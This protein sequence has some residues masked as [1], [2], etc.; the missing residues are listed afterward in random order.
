MKAS[1]PSMV[2][3][4]ERHQRS[5]R[6][7]GTPTR[8]RPGAPTPAG[9][10]ARVIAIPQKRSS[11]VALVARSP[12]ETRLGVRDGWLME[13]AETLVINALPERFVIGGIRDDLQLPGRRHRLQARAV[14]HVDS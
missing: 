6:R 5:V 10:P 3:S 13:P 8:A 7:V 14:A 4:G 9:D 11:G 1:R 2:I 12:V